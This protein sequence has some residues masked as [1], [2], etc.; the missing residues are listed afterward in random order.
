MKL[1]DDTIGFPT[2]D[3]CPPRFS[4]AGL[5]WP[6]GVDFPELV[7]RHQRH[8]TCGHVANS[9]A[10]VSSGSTTVSAG[11]APSNWQSRVNLGKLG[12]LGVSRSHPPLR[13]T[14][15]TRSAGGPSYR[16][17]V[18]SLRVPSLG[19]QCRPSLSAH[20]PAESIKLKS[21]MSRTDTLFN[22]TVRLATVDHRTPRVA[23]GQRAFCRL[24]LQY[25]CSCAISDIPL[26]NHGQSPL[27]LTHVDGRMASVSAGLVKCRDDGAR[28]DAAVTLD[29]S[30]CPPEWGPR[31]V[32]RRFHKSDTLPGT[33][34][35]AAQPLSGV[36]CN[37]S[38]T[39]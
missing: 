13:G 37:V 14:N 17:T 26:V 21:A 3:A 33:D 19:G 27:V 8:T 5:A 38:H 15:S 16:R 6:R 28:S 2:I 30:A 35:I 1:L 10:L 31:R 18:T 24:L 34:G 23:E 12:E 7:H 11:P 20:A 4:E 25:H 32:R 36:C 29:Q 39:A 9:H 22:H